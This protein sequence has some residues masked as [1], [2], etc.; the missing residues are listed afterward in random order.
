MQRKGQVTHSK[1]VSHDKHRCN[2]VPAN[3]ERGAIIR[4]LI[5]NE[6]QGALVKVLTIPAIGE[7]QS[8][9]NLL[10]QLQVLLQQCL[11]Q[12]DKQQA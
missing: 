11:L 2:L 1:E 6:T 8:S 3:N 10:I 9:Y 7:A 4:N 5:Q 12:M